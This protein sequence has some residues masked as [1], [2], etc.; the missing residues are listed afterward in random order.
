MK[1]RTRV[2]FLYL[3]IITLVLVCIGV[4]M[5]SSLHEQNLENVRTDSVN[6]L[7]HIDFALSNFIKEVK[8]DISEL[9]MHETVIDPDDRGFTSFLNVS[10]DTFQYDIG[11]REARI[12]DDLNAFR[13]THPAVN[14]V[15]MGRESGSFVRSHPRPVPTRYDPR[16]RPWYTLAKNN[17]EAVMITEPYQ[18]VT[19]PDV[20][21]GIVKA[22]MYPNG[23]VYGVL[24]AESP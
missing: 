6:Q 11:D 2:F 19:S 14:S 4:I 12:I 20:N 16:T 21:I 9:L 3:C 13:L 22:M 24:G 8:Q 7:R 10:E 5:P 17:P 15:Y 23:T 1:L 18:S